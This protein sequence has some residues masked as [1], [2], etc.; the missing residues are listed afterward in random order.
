MIVKCL[1]VLCVLAAVRAVPNNPH[2]NFLHGARGRISSSLPGC[3]YQDVLYNHGVSVSTP[4]PCLNCTCNKGVLLCNLRVCP[5]PRLLPSCKFHSVKGKCCPVI[6]CDERNQDDNVKK[7]SIGKNMDAI[8]PSD[9]SNHM[10]TE[11]PSTEVPN[12]NVEYDVIET[13]PTDVHTTNF[14]NEPAEIMKENPITTEYP[15]ASIEKA[16]SL[17]FVTSTSPSAMFPSKTV[18]HLIPGVCHL[19]GTVYAEGSAVISSHFCEYCYCIRGKK[20]CIRPKCQLSIDGCFPQYTHKFACCPTSYVCSGR[21]K[22]QIIQAST[23]AT[24]TTTTSE[25]DEVCELD[26]KIYSLGDAVPSTATCQNCYCSHH[27]VTCRPIECSPEME[28][29]VPVVPTGHCCPLEYVCNMTFTT[30]P[31]EEILN[32]VDNTAQL[33]TVTTPSDSLEERT[34]H[35]NV[36]TTY[37]YFLIRKKTFA[38][39]NSSRTLAAHWPPTTYVP[40][41]VIA[42]AVDNYK[43]TEIEENKTLSPENVQPTF[44]TYNTEHGL[45]TL[46]PRVM[47]NI[48]DR[49]TLTLKKTMVETRYENPSVTLA[50]E[51]LSRETSITN[52]INKLYT[53]N[54]DTN[55]GTRS[56]YTNNLNLT[57]LSLLHNSSVSGKTSSPIL[58]NIKGIIITSDNTRDSTTMP[59]NNRDSTTM[60]NKTEAG[61]TISDDI[62]DSTTMSDNI[63]DSTTVPEN[64]IISAR[65]S[66]N[67][68]TSTTMPG[69]TKANI[70]VL[71]NIIISSTMPENTVIMKTMSDNTK[72]S[73]KLLDNTDAT[74]MISANNKSSIIVMHNTENN[75]TV[76]DSPSKTQ[77]LSTETI[78]NVDKLTDSTTEDYFNSF[79]SDTAQH[80]RTSQETTSMIYTFGKVTNNS[81]QNQT[82]PYATLIPPSN[83]LLTWQFGNQKEFTET[84]LKEIPKNVNNQSLLDAEGE[85]LSTLF[86]DTS[87]EQTDMIST[88]I[89]SSLQVNETGTAFSSSTV[90]DK[91][92]MSVRE[93]DRIIY[94][95]EIDEGFR[96]LPTFHRRFSEADKDNLSLKISSKGPA[97]PFPRPLDHLLE[98]VESPHTEKH[99]ENNISNSD[100]NVFP[101]ILTFNKSEGHFTSTYVVES[102]IFN[103]TKTEQRDLLSTPVTNDIIPDTIKF[104]Q[105]HLKQNISTEET[106]GKN[107]YT[108]HS[109]KLMT[110]NDFNQTLEAVKKHTFN[111]M[112]P[113]QILFTHLQSLISGNRRESVLPI[114]NNYG[115]GGNSERVVE[116]SISFDDNSSVSNPKIYINN[117]RSKISVMNQNKHQSNTSVKNETYSKNHDHTEMIN[118]DVLHSSSLGIIPFVSEG[119]ALERGNTVSGFG[120]GNNTR[121]VPLI[122]TKPHLNHAVP[123]FEYQGETRSGLFFPIS[124]QVHP[125]HQIHPQLDQVQVTGFGRPQTPTNSGQDG[126]YPS[127]GFLAPNNPLTQDYITSGLNKRPINPKI[128][129]QSRPGVV[130][131][132]S[133]PPFN[134]NK[135]KPETLFQ[136]PQVVLNNYQPKLD[137]ADQKTSNKPSRHNLN[138]HLVSNGPQILPS[139]IHLRPNFFINNSPQNRQDQ[140]QSRLENLSVRPL[141]QNHPNQEFIPHTKHSST[142]SGFIGQNQPRP[143]FSNQTPQ[144]PTNHHQLRPTVENYRPQNPI[145]QTQLRPNL[146]DQGPKPN[147]SNEN[148]QRPTNH[149]QLRP[150]VENYRPQNPIRQTQLRPNLSDQGPKPNP[151]NENPQRPL[152]LRH[153]PQNPVKENQPSPNLSDQGPKQTINMQYSIPDNSHQISESSI[154]SSQS[155]LTVKSRIVPGQNSTSSF[156]QNIKPFSNSDQFFGPVHARIKPTNLDKI[157]T[158]CTVDGRSYNNGDTIPKLDPCSQCNCFFGSELCQQQQCPSPPSPKC[159]AENVVGFCCPRFT[160][161][162]TIRP[163][164]EDKAKGSGDGSKYPLTFDHQPWKT[165]KRVPNHFRKVTSLA[166]MSDI[167]D[168]VNGEI[169]ALSDKSISP[170]IVTPISKNSTVQNVNIVTAKSTYFPEIF[171]ETNNTL[172]WTVTTSSSG[173]ANEDL[174][175]INMGGLDYKKNV[176]TELSY[177]GFDP[178]TTSSYPS[179]T[180]ETSHS[181]LMKVS[182]LHSFV[183][184][185]SATNHNEMIRPFQNQQLVTK[186]TLSQPQVSVETNSYSSNWGLLKVSGCNIYGKFYKVNE[187]LEELGGPCKECICTDSGVKCNIIC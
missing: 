94:F 26:N 25:Y 142:V 182:H 46:V 121:P 108:E 89:P 98:K 153:N 11:L 175:I 80:V 7:Y 30:A 22:A 77:L 75:K 112:G 65:I 9:V 173:L 54:Q 167:G 12:V 131:F 177:T 60:L 43:Q 154:A 138:A 32:Q 111:E 68:R 55:L 149:H 125:V 109:I 16:H 56:E 141:Q 73:T 116:S 40:F 180:K 106:K 93:N 5:T 8:S 79:A 184:N 133:K 126:S 83:D 42:E 6:K 66:G 161:H 176:N 69:S 129:I 41:E 136:M 67:T 48:T 152:D 97:A 19:D 47:T 160:C 92:V 159:I 150:T 4:E 61:T 34:E 13:T 120:K 114:F 127:V 64:T 31:E 122:K 171:Q 44:E 14:R 58:D 113:L 62:T 165:T 85:S 137:T 52:K 95:P 158:S 128:Q 164:P 185:L 70:T 88:L 183:S 86:Y 146:S 115:S 139:R 104:Y 179:H 134:L 45:R 170:S 90:G 33:P 1:M 100:D 105:N 50:D 35:S 178:I 168:V 143:N 102:E 3:L 49:P 38:L 51:N 110:D 117:H 124:Y 172:L 145:R 147:P 21:R 39:S 81:T 144:R 174:L 186:K 187:N 24:T 76:P 130:K 119:G 28:G 101:D 78:T 87:I 15:S 23:P 17:M 181:T 63:R 18:L 82:F 156:I 91:A 27:G 140:T 36:A 99:K 132:S 148:P 107:N 10:K 151:S 155:N 135:S 59:G 72:T 37:D 2:F 169:S 163:L 29:C 157:P 162:E 123:N 20:M 103:S 96:E 74:T 84:T 53:H 118:D 57:I 71:G 166:T